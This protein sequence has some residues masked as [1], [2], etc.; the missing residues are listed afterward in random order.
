M[1]NI[2]EVQGELEGNDR[3]RFDR[4]CELFGEE[5]A[6]GERR[7]QQYIELHD[8][9]VIEA[10]ENFYNSE[11]I[12]GEPFYLRGFYDEIQDKTPAEALHEGDDSRKAAET[13][14]SNQYYRKEVI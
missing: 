13:L 7:I 1:I 14:I 2:E 8:G 12:N 6:D 9:D 11:I 4:M 3:E 10:V 5:T